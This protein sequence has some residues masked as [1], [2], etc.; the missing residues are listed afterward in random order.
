MNNVILASL[1]E[2]MAGLE[3]FIFCFR[4]NPYTSKGFLNFKEVFGGWQFYF[5]K[6]IN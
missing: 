3:Q 6:C 1:V 2:D 4:G 5:N